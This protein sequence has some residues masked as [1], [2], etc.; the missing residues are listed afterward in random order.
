MWRRLR[1]AG[2]TA[3]GHSRMVERGLVRRSFDTRLCRRASFDKLRMRKIYCFPVRCLMPRRRVSAVS[4]HRRKGRIARSCPLERPPPE[5]ALVHKGLAETG[6]LLHQAMGHD[7]QTHGHTGSLVLWSIYQHN[8]RLYGGCKPLT[9][10]QP[11]IR[12]HIASQFEA[13]WR[14]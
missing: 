9:C 3:G 7:D 14:L 13:I 12:L 4:T 1:G 10:G 11:H 8:P 2:M 6:G 5:F